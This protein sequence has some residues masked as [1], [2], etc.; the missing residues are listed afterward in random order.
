MFRLL[1]PYLHI[2]I[3][4]LNEK[5]N[6]GGKRGYGSPNMEKPILLVKGVANEPINR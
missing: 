5:E 1:S 3:T 4:K 6:A 2:K